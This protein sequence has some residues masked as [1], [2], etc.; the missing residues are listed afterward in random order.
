MC[1][2]QKHR[3]VRAS[4]Y[5]DT[6]TERISTMI[7]K[8]GTQDFLRAKKSQPLGERLASQTPR[9]PTV[10]RS[11]VYCLRLRGHEPSLSIYAVGFSFRLFGVDDQMIHDLMNV[12]DILR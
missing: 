11:S 6:N 1:Q 5:I 9:I 12:G 10:L 8:N 3:V 4:G 7:C 2:L